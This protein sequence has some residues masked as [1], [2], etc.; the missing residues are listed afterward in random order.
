MCVSVHYVHFAA[1]QARLCVFSAA[2]VN[3]LG[4]DSGEVTDEGGQR[5]KVGL[6][7]DWEGGLTSLR[8]S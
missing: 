3:C 5:S 1:S 7:T 2:K 6:D 8:K 4:W